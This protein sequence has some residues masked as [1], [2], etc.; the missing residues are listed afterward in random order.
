MTLEELKAEADSISKAVAEE[1]ERMDSM[2]KANI[3]EFE[4]L[5]TKYIPMAGSRKSAIRWI[6]ES[7]GL[8]DEL[9]VG[10]IQ[11]VLG[12][13]YNYKTEEFTDLIKKVS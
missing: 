12:L 5:V 1:M 3:N 13:P 9:D 7:E 4:A 2:N 10:Y 6:L 8:T 11:Y